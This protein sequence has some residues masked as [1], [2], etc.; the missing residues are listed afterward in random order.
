[1]RTTVRPLD[2]AVRM[3]EAL[4][5]EAAALDRPVESFRREAYLRHAEQ[6]GY[7]AFGAFDTADRLVGL[8]Y[9]H[10]DCRGQWWHEQI[11]PA[12]TAVG[13]EGW[14]DGAYVLVELHVLPARQAEGLGRALLTRLL[15]GVEQDRLL[16]SAEDRETPARRWYRRLGLRDLL[17]DFRFSSTDKPFAIMGGPLPLPGLALHRS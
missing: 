4:A 1:M 6:P 3:D 17:V 16:L 7:G 2:L 10:R 14:L 9:G 8:A 13:Q 15:A 12:L 5:V 11:A